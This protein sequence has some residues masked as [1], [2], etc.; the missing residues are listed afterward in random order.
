MSIV[1]GGQDIQ[2][3]LERGLVDPEVLKSF[4][5][6]DDHP[7]IS[8]LTGRFQVHL[9]LALSYLIIQEESF[10]LMHIVFSL[11]DGYITLPFG[12]CPMLALKIL[13][14]LWPHE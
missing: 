3:G 5:E 6:L 8:A 11:F 14:T 10:V 7:I 12:L 9:L 2:A 4:F 13:K 1:V